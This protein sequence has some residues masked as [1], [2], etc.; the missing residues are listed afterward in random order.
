MLIPVIII[1]IVVV[2]LIIEATHPG[3]FRLLILEPG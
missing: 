3:S 2:I 1:I